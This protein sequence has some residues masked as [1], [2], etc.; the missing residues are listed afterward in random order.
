MRVAAVIPNRN[1]GRYLDRAL[2][3]LKKQTVKLDEI[4]VVDGESTDNSRSVAERHGVTWI[5]TPPRRQ[6]DARNVGVKSTTCDLILPLDADDW[7]SPTF[8]ASTLPMMKDNIGV[9]GTGLVWPHGKIQWP[10]PPFTLERFLVG[11]LV[12]SCSLY[13]KQC[14]EDVGGFDTAR[15]YEDWLFWMDV[16]NAG[17]EI[18]F[19]R[20][21]LYHHCPHNRSSSASMEPG[22]HEEYI[23]YIV[24]KYRRVGCSA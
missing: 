12:F 17:W 23:D 3:S 7:I 24:Q 16:V 9:V 14:W 10:S 6:A 18:T 13:R 5:S 1:Y 15:T 21:A 19:V 20:E 2:T 4:I 11:N 8:L 22:Q